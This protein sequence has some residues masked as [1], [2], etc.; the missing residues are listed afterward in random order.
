MTQHNSPEEVDL[1][2]LFKSIGGF[3]KK[4][5]K[6]L[7]LVI[8]F[9]KKYLFLF[10]GIIV[11]G[12][13]LGYFLDRNSKQVYENRLIVIPNFE[14][15][16]YLYD[17]T[18]ELNFKMRSGDS[19]G[20]K[21]VF[22]DNYKAVK[23]IEIEPIID[24][25][26]FTTKSRE[27]IDVFRILFENQDMKEFVDDLTTSKQYKYQKLKVFIAG[28]DSEKLMDSLLSYLNE[29]EHFKQYQDIYIQNTSKRLSETDKML[30]QA[31]SVIK[32]IASA[33]DGSSA[34]PPVYASFNND[35]YSIF[36]YKQVL[37]TD[38]LELLKRSKDEGEIIKPVSIN[39]NILEGGFATIK[40]IIKIPLLLVVFFSIIFFFR[41]LYLQLRILAEDND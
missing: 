29:N 14:S 16:E 7:F 8:A 41:F 15:V 1:G 30:A 31:D 6:L 4:L 17:K 36:R 39:Y 11:V 5:A 20:L 37:L 38:Q 35:F 9:F 33:S 25:Y 12:V 21:M 32:S 24:I 40:S 3:F 23:K 34:N 22:G 28:K 13:I 18:E 10:I 27:N 19:L 2:Y 26:S